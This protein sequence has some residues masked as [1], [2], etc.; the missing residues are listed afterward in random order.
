MI[1]TVFRIETTESH[2]LPAAPYI[3]FSGRIYSKPEQIDDDCL[4]GV[5]LLE[6]NNSSFANKE[7]MNFKIQVVFEAEP[8]SRFKK[9]APRLETERLVF[10]TGI[11]DLEDVKIPFI[12]AKEID[13]LDDFGSSQSINFKMPFSRTQNFKNNL[14]I[15]KEKISE[16]EI[17]DY[18]NDE[19]IPTDDNKNV[20]DN[21][22]GEFE[23]NQN[24]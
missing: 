17:A 24:Y 5:E 8:D 10:I 18:K 22:K 20:D 2:M 4:F 16:N 11:L 21:K 13:L 1:S 23:I 14:L 9:L 15:K 3:P 19:K 12:E 7:K 6:Y